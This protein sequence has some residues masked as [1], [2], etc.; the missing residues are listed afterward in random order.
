[1]N[2]LGDAL[3]KFQSEESPEETSSRGTRNHPLG[4]FWVRITDDL[5][6]VRALRFTPRVLGDV[7]GDAPV[8]GPFGL[9]M[10]FPPERSVQSIEITSADGEIS[11]GQIVRGQGPPAAQILFPPSDVTIDLPIQVEWARSDPDG[12]LRIQHVLYS[13]QPGYWSP[14]RVNLHP[15]R[16]SVLFDPSQ[17]PPSGEGVIRVVVSDGTETRFADVT[18]LTVY[19]TSSAPTEPPSPLDLKI[20]IEPNPFV[21]EAW[22]GFDLRRDSDRT[23]V[24]IFDVQGR[25]VRTLRSGRLT[26]GSHRISWDG[27]TTER[28]EAAP[29]VYFVRVSVDGKVGRSQ[30][31]RSR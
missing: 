14:V 30:V 18:G 15:S 22:I 7:E 11:Y 31:I 17:Y 28:M 3:E 4:R 27:R 13:W 1:M 10:P 26:A 20:R 24:E 9:V 5:G 8:F 21:D 25:L 6:V 23:A 16:T 19:S 12:D 29:G 2:T